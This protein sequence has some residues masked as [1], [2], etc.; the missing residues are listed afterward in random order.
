MGGVKTACPPGA[1]AS[2]GA[3]SCTQCVAGTYAVAGSTCALCAPGQVAVAGSTACTSC[4]AGTA[5]SVDNT[6]CLACPAGTHAPTSASTECIACSG[7]T[8]SGTGAWNCTECPAHHVSVG[9]IT[10]M[11]CKPGS[12]ANPALVECSLC[13]T[14]T[15]SVDGTHYPDLAA[16]RGFGVV[17]MAFADGVR[18]LPWCGWCVQVL[19]AR[20][21][22]LG[23]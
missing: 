6:Q 17:L 14:G 22:I 3:T 21:A 11:H 13:A 8:I 2:L 19:A 10:C 23:S 1:A 9:K 12:E 5:P 4:P 20:P 15:A 18:S 7:N 16:P